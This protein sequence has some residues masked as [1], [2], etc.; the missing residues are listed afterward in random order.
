MTANNVNITYDSDA[1]VLSIENS[2]HSPIE[3]ARE[4]GNFVIHFGKGDEPVL[5]EVL[6]VSKTFRG[7]AAALKSALARVAA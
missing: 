7:Q 1:D 6:E 5:I 3:H 2:L 4:M